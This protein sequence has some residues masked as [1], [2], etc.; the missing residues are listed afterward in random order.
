MNLLLTALVLLMFIGVPAIRYFEKKSIENKTGER[1]AL[2]LKEQTSMWKVTVYALLA[3]IV[4]FVLKPGEVTLFT[5][6]MKLLFIVGLFVTEGQLRTSMYLTEKHAY[7]V[8]R[9]S[10][11]RF[12][13]LHQFRKGQIYKIDS[14]PKKKGAYRLSF[15]GEKNYTKTKDILLSNKEDVY[16]F[17]HLVKKTLDLYINEPI[18]IENHIVRDEHAPS[19][20][21]DTLQRYFYLL[22][23]LFIGIALVKE[24]MFAESSD[25]SSVLATIVAFQFVPISVYLI[26]YVFIHASGGQGLQK[27]KKISFK[28]GM[29]WYAVGSSTL[30]FVVLMNHGI[31]NGER[32]MVVHL[33]GFAIITLLCIS[34]W[35]VGKLTKFTVEKN[36]LGHLENFLV[37]VRSK[38]KKT[39]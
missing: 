16:V 18:E 12:I 37:F 13:R 33:I 7:L 20:P 24:W 8:S 31:T 17:R 28:Q 6:V 3:V 4:L 34:S 11:K 9:M 1:I 29:F 36:I 21:M 35:I 2:D 22:S 23:L 25:M 27:S 39:P 19:G 26:A 10:Q 15:S 32:F 30:P 14:I 5:G 38:Q